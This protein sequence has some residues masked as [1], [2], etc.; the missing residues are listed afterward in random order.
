[1]ILY[2]SGTDNSKHVAL[3]MCD[4][5][6]VDIKDALQKKRCGFRI[7]P[8]EA[9]GIVCPVYYSGIPKTVID[10][11][12][13]FKLKGEI[14]YLYGI[15]TH[16]GGPGGAGSML[17]NE[18]QKKGYPLHA[19]FDVKMPS[20]YIMFGPLKDENEEK[21]RIIDAEEI[22][23]SIKADVDKR[24]QIKPDWSKLDRVLTK[25][26]Y[27]LCD[28]YMSTK[29]FYSD[30]TCVGCGVCAS[31]CPSK[32][33]EMIDGKPVWTQN[34]CVRCMACLRCNAVQYGEKTK[35]Y[36]RYA[37]KAPVQEQNCKSNK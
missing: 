19:C 8:G 21:Q 11:I 36:R 31:R 34:K 30:D 26:M 35:T 37:Y 12:R 14:S 2:F 27:L 25:S 17:E 9:V 5:R 20:N 28:R 6:V 18:L 4:E 1:M 24:L 29:K 22:I 16:G 33:I 15:L 10:F 32:C 13:H 23:K 7:K 3:S